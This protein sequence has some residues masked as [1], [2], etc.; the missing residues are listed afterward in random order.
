MSRVNFL[1][2]AIERREFVCSAELVLGRDHRVE[3]A[4]RFTADAAAGGAVR[5][6]S[7][8]DLPGGHPA[9]P[10]DGFASVIAAR[11]LTPIAHLTGKDGNRALLEGRLHGLAYAGVECVLALTGD[12]QKAAFGGV[13]R[14]VHDLD[15]VLILD[16]I[17]SLR[18][19][20]P[21]R[22]GAREAATTPFDFFPGAVVNPYKVRQ[23]DLMMQLYK[24][25][26][27]IAAGA[28]FIVTQVGFDLRK[29]YELRQYM[30]REGL[31][32][33]PVLANVY[34]PTAR[35][36]RLMRDGEIAGCV[37]PDELVRRLEGEKKPERLE[38][39]ALMLAAV[40][41]LG[42]AGAHIGGH[43]LRYADV[44]WVI[45]RAAALGPA[46]RDRMDELVFPWRGGFYLLPPGKGG[47]SDGAGAY[48]LDPGRRR[49][50]FSQRVSRAA[51]R[52][53]IAPGSHGAR[54]FSR[55][56]RPEGDAGAVAS[57]RRGFWARLLA[58]SSAYRHE[59]LGC[60]DCGDCIQ[61]HLSY[62]GCS[63]RL[64]YKELRNGPCGGSRPDGSCEARPDRPCLWNLVYDATRAVGEDPRRFARVL[65]P[66]RDWRLSGTN[67]L[68]NRFA[69]V[70]NLPRRRRLPLP[71]TAPA[72]AN[73]T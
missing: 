9:M 3:D 26:L 55:R 15:S 39:A 45:E 22:V 8:T 32:D 67:A 37:V 10:P 5:V 73:R 14:P 61:D 12:A 13:A 11:G 49:A 16:L 62:A 41:E 47:L 38:R 69:D 1:R 2:E 24:M 20:L 60:A 71:Q 28:R 21:Y 34:V 33:V 27:K 48:R 65:V 70:D 18:A 59:L 36:A 30:E 57:W 56:I 40:R 25:E 58:P 31:G 51:H 29:L 68:A 72:A 53:L 54:F 4:E 23:P 52:L 7:V 64:C 42:F 19:G 46:W 35:I 63:M 44:A 50:K 17:E 6:I 66:P 43:G